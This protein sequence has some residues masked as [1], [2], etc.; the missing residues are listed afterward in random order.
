MRSIEEI[1]VALAEIEDKVWYDRHM[2][3]AERARSSQLDSQLD[4]WGSQIDMAELSA[5]KM[6]E[7]Y[8]VENLGPYSDFEWGMLCGK[9]SALRWLEGSEWDDL[10]S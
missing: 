5:Q 8:G 3:L 9:L 4:L 10:S 6:R 7:K 2:M 1:G